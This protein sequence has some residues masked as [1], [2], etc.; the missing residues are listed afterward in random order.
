MKA[1]V[2]GILI[3]VLMIGCFEGPMGPQGEKGDKGDTGEQGIQGEKGEKGDTGEQGQQGIQGEQGIQ[4]IQGEK[5]EQGIQGEKGDSGDGIIESWTHKIEKSEIS[6]ISESMYLIA[7]ED[8]RF[9]I[10]CGYEFWS[11]N[12]DGNSMIRMDGNLNIPIFCLFCIG[13]GN[14]L[15]TWWQDITDETILIIKTKS[16]QIS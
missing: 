12:E 3:A 7:L 9:E 11:L 8:K 15:I 10:N 13:N 2:Q 4:G 5:G 6:F 14:C 16:N 1:I